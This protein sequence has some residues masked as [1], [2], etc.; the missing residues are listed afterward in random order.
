MTRADYVEVGAS[1]RER[2]VEAVRSDIRTRAIV[3]SVRRGFRNRTLVTGSMLGS[4]LYATR[5]RPYP[6]LAGLVFT[7]R[8][9]R[10]G[11][12]NPKQHNWRRNAKVP[13][14][15]INA[16]TLNTGHNWQF[17]ARWMGEPPTY[18]E[19]EIDAG[20]R[21]R[22]LYVSGQAPRPHDAMPI[23]LAVAASAAV[24]GVFPPLRLEQSAR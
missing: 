18:I 20:E 2:L 24:P 14:L 4:A 17:T 13:I 19:P 22:R 6:T 1:V 23:W 15:I 8:G 11:D 7:P 3:R 10:G 21:L 9:H 16:T 12:F 5:E